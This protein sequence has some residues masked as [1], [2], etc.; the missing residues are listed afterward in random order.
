MS[1]ELIDYQLKGM[2]SRHP[3]LKNCVLYRNCMTYVTNHY[4]HQHA[5]TI[6][7]TNSSRAPDD[8]RETPE[9][10][11]ALLSITIIIICILLVTYTISISIF[12][13]VFICCTI[14]DDELGFGGLQTANKLSMLYTRVGR[15]LSAC[16]Y[17]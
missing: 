17:V 7:C 6:G 8:G 11:R 1:T 5:S 14:R 3:Q 12:L 4:I 15:P 10:C 9:S 13:Y 16:V 2:R